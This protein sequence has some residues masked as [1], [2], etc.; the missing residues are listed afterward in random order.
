MDNHQGQQMGISFL[1]WGNHHAAAIIT[2]IHRRSQIGTG[3][4]DFHPVDFD[5]SK[6]RNKAVEK[7]MDGDFGI[8]NVFF[9]AGLFPF[10]L[11]A[12]LPVDAKSNAVKEAIGFSLDIDERQISEKAV[13]RDKTRLGVF[14]LFD[15]F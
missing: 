2:P 11:H 14:M 9:S 8:I 4:V 13:Q 6:A 10:R 7:Q 15:V 3:D 1:H 5:F 12:T